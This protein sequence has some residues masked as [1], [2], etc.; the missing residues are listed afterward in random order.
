MPRAASLE[1]AE[2]DSVDTQKTFVALALCPI[3]AWAGVPRPRPYR[4][5]GKVNVADVKE[6]KSC[7]VAR[8]PRAPHTTRRDMR[9]ATHIIHTPAAMFRG[10]MVM[11][12]KRPEMAQAGEQET[13]AGI[14]S[15]ERTEPMGGPPGEAPSSPHR[16]ASPPPS[17]TSEAKAAT[18]RHR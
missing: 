6:V 2:L 14:S 5:S 16:R 13:R 11:Q 4:G 10:W 17:E 3:K 8:D 12:L 1:L 7:T 15:G 18:P 9:A